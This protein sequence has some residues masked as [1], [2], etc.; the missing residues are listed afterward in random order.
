[1]TDLL[2]YTY[3]LR[4]VIENRERLLADEVASMNEN[5]VLNTSQ[6][7]MVQYQ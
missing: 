6:E 7:D 5:E 3:D 2:F 4:Q 1:M